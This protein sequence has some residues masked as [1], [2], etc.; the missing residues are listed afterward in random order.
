MGRFA[1]ASGSAASSAMWRTASWPLYSAPQPCA[2]GRIRTELAAHDH[3][4]ESLRVVRTLSVLARMLRSGQALS[5][6]P[7][8]VAAI[9]FAHTSWGAH[10]CDTRWA[11]AVLLSE[12]RGGATAE[13]PPRETPFSTRVL[14]FL[15]GVAAESPHRNGDQ[16]CR[17]PSACLRG[18]RYMRLSVLVRGRPRV[19]AAVITIEPWLNAPH[20]SKVT[21][22]LA[23]LRTARHAAA[24]TRAPVRITRRTHPAIRLR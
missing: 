5:M 2:V 9:T 19:S 18:T 14:R 6:L 7:A 21:G 13:V 4:I 22:P 17:G 24:A 20:R 10:G 3:L 1:P 11:R 23:E 12:H 15:R 16:R 8:A